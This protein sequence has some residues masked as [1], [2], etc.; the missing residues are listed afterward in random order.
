[1]RIVERRVGSTYILN[2]ALVFVAS[3]VLDLALRVCLYSDNFG[4]HWYYTI[5]TVGIPYIA[6]NFKITK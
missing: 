4:W 3:L 2:M 5:F 6:F 1:M